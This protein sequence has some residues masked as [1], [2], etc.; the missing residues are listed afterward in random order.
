ME[1]D[2]FDYDELTRNVND[3]LD[4]EYGAREDDFDFLLDGAG[5]P[6]DPRQYRNAAN[7]YGM[8]DEQSPD[9]DEEAAAM[10]Y[11]PQTNSGAVIHAY[12]SDYAT[13]AAQKANRRKQPPRQEHKSDREE[14][15]QRL[16]RQKS[17]GRED[18]TQ[19]LPRQ[20]SGD[21]RSD[22]Q[23]Q[24]RRTADGR[25]EILDRIERREP[26]RP[27]PRP[28][29]EREIPPVQAPVRKKKKH[30]FLKILLVLLLL[31]ALTIAALWIFAKQPDG[32]SLGVH[33]DGCS[34]I[35]LAGTDAEGTRTDTMMI[36]YVDRNSGELNLLSL[37]RDTY[38]SMDTDVPKL[39]AVYS[40]AGCGREGMDRLMD[41]TAE[42]IGYRPDGYILVDLKCFEHLVNIMGGVRYDVPCDMQYDDPAQD[43][44]IDLE[45][46]EQ[47]LNGK[48]A[49]WLVRYRSGYANADLGR[50][51]VQRDFMHAALKQWTS[52]T[53]IWR[54]PA[55]AALLLAN[56]TSDLD[57]LELAWIAKAVKQAGTDDMHNDTLPGEPADIYGGSY[58]VLWPETT[59]SL[60]NENYNPYREEVSPWDIYSPF[61]NS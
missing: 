39:N 6:D 60:V 21:R 38:T 51:E 41:Y 8:D 9:F 58:Y 18:A 53:K 49:M 14:A 31:L 30:V 2:P 4:D 42:C 40:L 10:R 33:R 50:V 20:K 34:A 44:H 57:V 37:P 11:D 36:L 17:S 5:L 52:P 26:S 43:L 28:V 24:P 22:V 56:T 54:S 45:A 35:L 7:G 16:P 25:Q 29:Q 3:L 48:K 1:L 46:G 59:A 27:A 32:D 55:A 15:T 19:R 47:K 23:R 13:R 12:N 61:Y